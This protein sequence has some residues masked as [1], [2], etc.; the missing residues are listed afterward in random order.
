MERSRAEK[1]EEIVNRT[2]EK[3][4]RVG[5]WQTVV[6]IVDEETEVIRRNIRRIKTDYEGGNRRRSTRNIKR[7]INTRVDSIWIATDILAR[8][9]NSLAMAEES[10]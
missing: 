10:K 7:S 2:V 4:L 9:A 8:I 6:D 5:D 3:I 1:N